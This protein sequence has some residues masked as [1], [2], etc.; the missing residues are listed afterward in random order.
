[1]IML[2]DIPTY[3]QLMRPVLE[4]AKQT[5]RKISDVVEEISDNLRLSEEQRNI[6]LPSGK[7]TVIANR[8]HWARSYLK[9]AGLVKNTQ[10]GWFELTSIGRKVVEDHTV[11][12]NTRY[13]EQFEEFQEFRQRSGKAVESL[14]VEAPSDSPETPDEQIEVAF[15]RWNKTLSSDLLQATQNASPVFLKT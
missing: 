6:L 15:G 9:Q 13:L 11:K 7:Q 4:A 2:S 3:Q 8:V 14:L 10:R 5:P 1:M 12:L